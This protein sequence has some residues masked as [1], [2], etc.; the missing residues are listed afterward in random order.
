MTPFLQF[1]MKQPRDKSCATEGT[2]WENSAPTQYA[3]SVGIELNLTSSMEWPEEHFGSYEAH[4]DDP[5]TARH[6]CPTFPR[7]FENKNAPIDLKVM[8]LMNDDRDEPKTF[9]EL[10]DF[11]KEQTNESNN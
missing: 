9:G 6:L 5:S 1:V 2:T 10:Q 8:R 11:I 4:E 7:W 3:E